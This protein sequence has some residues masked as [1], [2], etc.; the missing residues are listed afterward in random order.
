[1]T[2][3]KLVKW[4]SD[5]LELVDNDSVSDDNFIDI[6]V[7]GDVKRTLKGEH[8]SEEAIRIFQ[9]PKDR[10]KTRSRSRSTSVQKS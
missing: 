3:D 8:T 9:Y 5:Y 6:F 10:T 2:Y 7:S 4:L 1:M